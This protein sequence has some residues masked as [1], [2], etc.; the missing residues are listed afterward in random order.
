MQET[1]TKHHYLHRPVDGRC[2]VEAYSIL[3][4]TEPGSFDYTQVIGL[5][6]F[7]RPE[8]TRCGSWYG[9]VQDVDSGACEVTRWQVLNLARVW[10]DPEVQQGGDLH[11]SHLLPGYTDRC[12]IW[13]STLASTA[14][15]LAAQRV[16]YEYLLRR[17]PCFLD[18]PYEIRYLMSYC[19]RSQHKGTIYRESGFELYRTNDRQIETWRLRLPV[20]M[21]M[22]DRVVQE[23]SR[24]N[25]RAIQ[26]RSQRRQD[27][28]QLC[29]L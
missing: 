12:G 14:I 20:L 3:L 5:L 29:F 22:Q 9:S 7:G 16:G 11:K 28:M 8:A 18:E 1:V 15:T 23:V 25:P 19:D 10:L 2:S 26:Y 27:A 17:P 21:P 13:R 6:M 24:K 4:V